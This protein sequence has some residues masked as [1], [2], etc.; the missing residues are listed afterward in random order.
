ME[1]SE[2][3]RSNRSMKSIIQKPPENNQYMYQ[4]RNPHLNQSERERS[5]RC[6]PKYTERWKIHKGHETR[7]VAEHTDFQIAAAELIVAAE[8]SKKA[9]IPLGAPDGLTDNASASDGEPV[10]RPPGW[11]RRGGQRRLLLELGAG[12]Q[13]HLLMRLGGRFR[14]RRRYLFRTLGGGLLAAVGVLQ[15]RAGLLQIRHGIEVEQREREREIKY[16]RKREER[17]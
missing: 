7:G 5:T 16:A 3:Q 9:G 11:D 12:L 14:W 10:G 6:T 1:G 17:D 13:G 8:A 15:E 4:I 2:Q